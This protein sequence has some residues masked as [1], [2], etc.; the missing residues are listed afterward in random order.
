MYTKQKIH[1]IPLKMKVMTMTN[2]SNLMTT[3]QKE[4]SMLC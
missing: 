2:Y 1:P 4:R 3:A